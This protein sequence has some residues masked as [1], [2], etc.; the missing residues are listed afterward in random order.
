MRAN[1][2]SINPHSLIS[3]YSNPRRLSWIQNFRKKPR[4]LGDTRGP[5]K[6]R[7]FWRIKIHQVSLFLC[8]G[9]LR[10]S[11][12]SKG[13]ILCTHAP[14]INHWGHWLTKA[15]NLDQSSKSNISDYMVFPCWTKPRTLLAK[16]KTLGRFIHG[17]VGCEEFWSRL[18]YVRPLLMNSPSS[19]K[20]TVWI[21]SFF[22]LDAQAT[23]NEEKLER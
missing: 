5:E 19:I 6:C 22:R 20:F 11:A 9:W 14:V 2:R 1:D 16:N 12:T 17:C 4:L 23:P 13:P 15:L 3:L 8:D 18:K 7:P 10:P 21:V